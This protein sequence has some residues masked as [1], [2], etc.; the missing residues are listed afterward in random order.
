MDERI[1]KYE[2]I[3]KNFS[4][5]EKAILYSDKYDSEKAFIIGIVIFPSKKINEKILGVIQ[6]LKKSAPNNLFVH[7]DFLHI[8]FQGIAYLPEKFNT[9]IYDEY[10]KRIN[11]AI[12]KIK[13]FKL[14]IKGIN[15]FP[16]VLFAQVFSEDNKLYKYQQVLEKLFPE[17]ISEF[18]YVPHITMAQ[19]LEKPVRLF[20][21]VNQLN[22]TFFGE[23]VA[24]EIVLVKCALPSKG[25]KFEIIKTFKI[26]DRKV[27]RES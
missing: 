6:E 19:F 13:P 21:A 7:G 24:D 27:I 14:K 25:E 1:K 8:T 20:R 4:N 18:E 3:R 26:T 5:P 9:S 17:H 12:K 22:N 11:S 23:M 15:N 16:N 2:E 10:I